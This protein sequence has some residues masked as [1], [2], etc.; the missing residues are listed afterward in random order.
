MNF[1]LCKEVRTGAGF[2]LEA[3][4]GDL[5]PLSLH[6]G[7][8]S[9]FFSGARPDPSPA[10]ALL[11]RHKHSTSGMQR[12]LCLP[13]ALL[14]TCRAPR[15]CNAPERCAS[16]LLLHMLFFLLH[17]SR[18]SKNIGIFQTEGFPALPYSYHSSETLLYQV[19]QS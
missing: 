2:E 1:F 7:S 19:A 9:G 18:Y 3:V 14:P 11:H 8:S 10:E 15:H 17:A 12:V 4:T 13:A 6:T 16:M 5:G